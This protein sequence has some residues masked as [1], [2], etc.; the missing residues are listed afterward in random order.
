LALVLALLSGA[1]IFLA[2]SRLRTAPPLPTVAVLPFKDL[3][4]RGQSQYLSNGIS[5][6]LTDLL[7]MAPDLRVIARTSAFH[8]QGKNTDV[9]EIGREL[10]A[11][12]VIEGSILSEGDRIRVLVELDRTADGARLWKSRYERA[13]KDLPGIEE[14]ITQAVAGVLQVP[15]PPRREVAFDP[16]L[17]ARDEFL[18]GVDAESK[19]DPASLDLA[20]AHY[21]NAL[22]LAPRYALAHVRLGSVYLARSGRT[23]PSQKAALEKARQELDAAVSL[24][25]KLSG[26]N[27]GLALA[28]YLLTWDWPSAEAGF[29][30]ALALGSSSAA[31]QTYAWALMTRGRFAESERHY[32]EA[33]ERDPLDCLLRYNLATLYSREGRAAAARGELESCLAREPDWFLGRMALGYFELFDNRPDQGLKDLRQARLMAPGSPALDAGFAIADAELGR[34][35]E[36]LARLRRMESEADT[37]NYVRYQL[38]IAW[39][40]LKDRDRLF[41]WL[42]QSVDLHEQQALNMRID[43]VLEPYQQ[44]ARMIS[45]ERRTGLLP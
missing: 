8:F 37:R 1:G 26:A 21:Q 44:D 3:T 27:A 14:E 12:W 35:G 32:Q 9:R 30:R 6:E 23:G 5:E 24:D 33:I 18:K 16:G 20:E 17:D 4:P 39:A 38:A 36:A 13:A 45:L 7:A 15:L 28:N 34:R 31:H 10:G 42:G 11:G 41:Y 43:P 40:Y 2:S 29:R 25:P 19:A 22:R